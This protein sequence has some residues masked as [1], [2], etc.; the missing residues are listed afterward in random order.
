MLPPSLG[1]PILP[2]M[3]R[4]N[5]RNSLKAFNSVEYEKFKTILIFSR[6]THVLT[7]K[8]NLERISTFV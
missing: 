3:E 6:K 7:L 5:L 1:A 2:E 8:R 4:A